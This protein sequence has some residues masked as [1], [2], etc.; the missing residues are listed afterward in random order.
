VFQK[1]EPPEESV[2]HSVYFNDQW[3]TEL[4]DIPNLDYRQCMEYWWNNVDPQLSESERECLRDADLT[5]LPKVIQE[6]VL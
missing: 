4:K 5:E 6:F 2:E 3:I 1:S